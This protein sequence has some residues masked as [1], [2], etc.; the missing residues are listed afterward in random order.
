MRIAFYTPGSK[1]VEEDLGAALLAGAPGDIKFKVLK[2][3]GEIQD[4]FDASCVIG[5][6]GANLVRQLEAR[7][8]PWIY[9]DKAY[10]RDWPTYWRVS[11]CGHQPTDYLMGLN[12]PGDRAAEQGWIAK[13]WRKPTS[14]G[15]VMFAGASLKYHKFFDLGDP[16]EYAEDVV[17]QINARTG[18]RVIYRPKPSWGAAAPVDGAEFS[19]TASKRIDHPISKDIAGA[20]VVVTHGSAA[21]LD[22]L[23]AGVP[24]IVLGHA[25]TRSISSTSLDDLENPREASLEECQRLMANLAYCQFSLEEIRRGMAWKHLRLLM[26]TVPYAGRVLHP[27][28]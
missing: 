23:R 11:Y 10:N 14:D 5:V 7:G 26:G 6:K 20:H 21:A 13:P 19:W 24:A 1:A 22:G 16:T 25:V 2:N 28:S 8:E 3:T 9:W 17:R 15:H 27:A 18:R 4:G 12:Y